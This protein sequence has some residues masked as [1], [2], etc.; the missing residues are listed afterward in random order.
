MSGEKPHNVPIIAVIIP[1]APVPMTKADKL[2][3]ALDFNKLL[4]GIRISLPTKLA[5]IRKQNTAPKAIIR[6]FI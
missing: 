2:Y 1:I 4:L 6:S 5:T 3:T